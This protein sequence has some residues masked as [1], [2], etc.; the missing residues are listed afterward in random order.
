MDVPILRTRRRQ[1][2]GV[3][4]LPLT[5]L[6]LAL[7]APAAAN[8]QCVDFS[9]DP[10][11][12]Q[13]STFDTPIGDM[14]SVR[15]DRRGRIDPFSSEEQARTGFAR[16]ERELHLFRNFEHLHWVI[17]VPSERDEGTGAWRGGDLD[18]AGDARGMGIA[19]S[20]IFAGHRN[21]PGVIREIDIFRIQPDPVTMPP[22]KVG[23]LPAMSLG[24]EGFDDRELRAL[25][26]ADASGEDRMLL[27]RNAGTRTIGRL[28]TFEIDMETC[29]PLGKS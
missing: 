6:V 8:A 23:E 15:V 22:L 12:C 11:G 3:V 14:P 2:G 25:V 26:Y 16:L 21:G 20:C 19:G 27:V 7:A 5:C 9:A 17:T 10:A 13:P 18:G 29:L 24:N 4:L 1:S 28:E